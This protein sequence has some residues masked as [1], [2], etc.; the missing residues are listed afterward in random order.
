M[1]AF[2]L[3]SVL[4]TTVCMMEKTPVSP[5]YSFSTSL[6]SGNSRF[7][8]GT[9]PTQ[10][11]KSA[12]MVASISP[13][14]SSWLNDLPLLF[15]LIFTGLINGM[16]LGFPWDSADSIDPCIHSIDDRS[17]PCCFSIALIHTAAVMVYNCTPIFLPFRSL[18]VFTDLLLTAMKP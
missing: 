5:K 6:K 14:S 1:G 10:A 12:P 11:G 13:S 4:I 17:T 18:R 16:V 9:V 7:T 8:C 2:R 15:C 3:S